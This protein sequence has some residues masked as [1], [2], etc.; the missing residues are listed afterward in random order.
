MLN[1]ERQRLILNM[2]YQN[3][4]VKVSELAEQFNVGVETI[5][6]D[7]KALATESDIEIIYGGAHLKNSTNSISVHEKTLAIKR[8]ENYE[9]KQ[10]IA[11]K[12]A[13]L[14]SPGDI[15]ALNSGS[16]VEFMLDFL[17]SKTPLDIITLNVHVMEKA[18]AIPD[19]NVYIPGGKVRTSSGMII[20]PSTADFIGKFAIDKCFLGISAINLSHGIT[21]PVMDE[22]ESNR[23]L[24]SVSSKKYV[25]SDSS[26]FNKQSLVQMAKFDEVDA[27]IVDN[28][29]PTNYRKYMNLN[30]IEV[31]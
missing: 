7:L 18:L 26:K 2:I 16:T 11:K 29:L 15:I 20:G 19:V 27:F 12:A 14:V 8:T 21:H 22:V 28:E 23:K 30:K 10:L 9:A 4:S 31:I 6:R 17:Y 5:R 3:G 1:V 25:V 24:L 13:N